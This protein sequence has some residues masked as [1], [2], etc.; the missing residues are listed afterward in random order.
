MKPLDLYKTVL[1]NVVN[2]TIQ[3]CLHEGINY[4]SKAKCLPLHFKACRADQNL[5]SVNVVRFF[6]SSITKVEKY[7][8]ESTL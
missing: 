3:F 7:V 6:W 2:S 8:C 4:C 1:V 5:I